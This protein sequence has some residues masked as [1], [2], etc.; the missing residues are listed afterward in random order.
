LFVLLDRN[1]SWG[2]CWDYGWV[3]NKKKEE[4]KKKKIGS[5]LVAASEAGGWRT[6]ERRRS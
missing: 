5:G 1:W 3:E 2:D 6:R 4:E